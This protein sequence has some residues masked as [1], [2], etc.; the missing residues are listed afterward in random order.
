MHREMI[1]VTVLLLAMGAVGCGA[2]DETHFRDIYEHHL[3]MTE[4]E[5]IGLLDACPPEKTPEGVAPLQV[6][7]IS[8]PQP[9]PTPVYMAVEFSQ[10]MSHERATCMDDYL[11]AHGAKEFETDTIHWPSVET[12]GGST[13]T[14]TGP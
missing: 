6:R 14:S 13:T 4:E 10:A 8:A 12:Y 5:F 2:A 9:P 11:K 3:E 1:A 7:S